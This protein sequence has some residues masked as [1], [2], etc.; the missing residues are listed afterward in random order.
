MMR[1]SCLRAFGDSPGTEKNLQNLNG[2]AIRKAMAKKIFTFKRFNV[3]E[4][5][6]YGMS[7]QKPQ[8]SLKP[9][10]MTI[11]SQFPK[12]IRSKQSLALLTAAVSG[13]MACSAFAADLFFDDFESYSA[14]ST[15]VWDTVGGSTTLRTVRDEATDTPF[16]TPNQYGEL[17]DTTTSYVR[18]QSPNIAAA[19]AAVTTLSF[20]FYE[21]STGGSDSIGFGYAMADDQLNS[22]GS[23][24][25]LNLDNGTIGGVTGGTATYSLDTAY[26]IRVIFN[27]TASPVDYAEGTVAAGTADVWLE[28]LGSGTLVFAGTAEVTNSQTA[29]YRIGFRTFTSPTQT[30]LVDDVALAS[31]VVLP[32]GPPIIA[33]SGQPQSQNVVEGTGLILL[34]VTAAGDEPLTYQWKLDGVDIP[35]ATDRTLEIGRPGAADGGDYTV[36]VSNT[37]GDT[38][39]D[40][41]TVTLVAGASFLVDDFDSYGTGL[42]ETLGTDWSVSLAGSYS[43]IDDGSGNNF[44][45]CLDDDGGGTAPSLKPLG[46]NEIADGETRTLFSRVYYDSSADGSL[47]FGTS[48]SSAS[49]FNAFKGYLTFSGNGSIGIRDGAISRIASVPLTGD[50]WHNVWMIHNNE[51]DTYQVFLTTE[52][53]D[54]TL[55]DRLEDSTGQYE[56]AFRNGAAGSI[57]ELQ[58][59]N[60]ATTGAWL[61][62]DLYMSPLINLA[63]PL[64]SSVGPL[65]I[66]IVGG[67]AVVSWSGA[68]VL[69][70]STTLETGSFSDVDGGAATSPYNI[71]GPLAGKAFFRLRE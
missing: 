39:S 64:G 65:T 50:R 17:A 26:T 23:R 19:S 70:S 62:D 40:P 48:T 4:T 29:S 46:L 13:G 5:D 71:P 15:V 14:N 69:Q 56:F 2:R 34:S 12:M 21:P 52:D 24:L 3:R 7:D 33:V 37:A 47:W 1:W 31:G 25:R 8:E 9:I 10:V 6:G 35:G 57:D 55:A 51:T 67:D 68:G 36:V 49:G 22:G 41:A 63:F 54:A 11:F 18:I 66:E 59:I 32:G 27:D 30:L 16:G 61:V 43:V 60:R 44:L 42:V 45:A 20:D 58:L 53:R 28:A 38:T